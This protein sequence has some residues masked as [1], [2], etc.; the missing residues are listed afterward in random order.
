MMAKALIALLW[1]PVTAALLIVNLLLLSSLAQKTRVASGAPD[2]RIRVTASAYGTEQVLGTSI[3]AGDARSSLL[4]QFLTKNRSP[5]SPYADYIIDRADYYRVDFRMVPSIAMCESNVGKRIPSRDSYNA[6]GISVATG[7][8][9]GAK[10]PNWIYAIDW[11]TRYI[12]EKYLD[13]GITELTDIGAIWAPPSVGTG[14]SWAN[15]VQFFM[16][17]IK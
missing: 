14:N 1:F 2:K 8:V 17:E 9:N 16:S 4:A 11:V 7:T 12:K 6:W 13:R 10:F 3:Q 15:C 5:L